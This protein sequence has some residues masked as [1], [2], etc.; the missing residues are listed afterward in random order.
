LEAS[1][2]S[3]DRLTLLLRFD[4]E[5]GSREVKG[6]RKYRALVGYYVDTMGYDKAKEYIRSSK[7]WLTRR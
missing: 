2:L 5:G 1:G 4:P 3:G 6:K 7:R